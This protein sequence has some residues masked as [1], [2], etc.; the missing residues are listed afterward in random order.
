VEVALTLA[1]LLASLE[2]GLP[3]LLTSTTPAGVGLLSRRRPGAWRP[4]P[5]DVPSSVRRFFDASEPRLLILVET[6]LWPVVLGEARRRGTPVLVVNARLSQRSAR[7]YRR[8][9][10]LFGGSWDALT[11]VLARTRE[12]AIRFKEI[13][14][15]PSRVTVGGDLKFDRAPAPEPPFA[16]RLR[17]LADGRPTLVAGSIAESEIPL[18]LEVQR[19]LGKSLPGVFLVLAPR[20]PDAFDAAER[21]ARAEGLRV[22]RRSRLNAAEEERADVFLLDSVGELAGT[23]TLGEAALL[24]GSFAPKGG[25]NV[26][27]PLRAGA[28]VVH[29]PSTGNIRSALDAAEGAVFAA[30][31]ARSAADVLRPLLTDPGTRARASAIARDLFAGHAGAA[32][33]AAEA[34]LQLAR[35]GAPAA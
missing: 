16:G 19:W 14:V 20:Q 2:P 24:G 7:R 13:G 15:P 1:D 28:P 30:A 27:E 4:F 31:D 5:L 3:L 26:L 32:R 21:L 22:V 17:R 8:I 10:R 25:H 18:V 9:A 29:G 34:A 23:Y 12:D 35:S 11:Q 33:T 6:E